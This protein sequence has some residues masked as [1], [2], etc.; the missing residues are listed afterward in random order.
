MA[1]LDDVDAVLGDRIQRAGQQNCVLK[2]G[3]QLGEAEYAMSLPRWQIEP[4]R[5]LLP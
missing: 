2:V 4:S 3:Q 1:E 5:Q